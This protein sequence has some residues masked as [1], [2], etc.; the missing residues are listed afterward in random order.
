MMRVQIIVKRIIIVFSI[1]VSTASQ[2]F[3]QILKQGNTEVIV[4]PYFYWSNETFK[5]KV[6]NSDGLETH[7]EH[8]KLFG[9]NVFSNTTKVGQAFELASSSAESIRVLD[10]TEVGIYQDTIDVLDLVSIQDFVGI[11]DSR[12]KKLIISKCTKT[13]LLEIK[14]SAIDSII[15]DSNFEFNRDSNLKF[16]IAPVRLTLGY[17]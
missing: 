10:Y 12:I 11:Y 17:L 1:V 16:S 15:L 3:G 5:N 2:H 6:L 14:N 4:R 7:I 13:L 9:S 8:S